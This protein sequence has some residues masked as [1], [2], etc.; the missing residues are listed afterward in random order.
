MNYS[1]YKLQFNTGVHF[2]TGVL[3]ESE[4]TFRAD[5][6]FSAL[7]IEALKQ[8]SEKEL[9][10]AVC[11]G[12]LLFSD[13]FPYKGSC[14]MLPKPM[15]YVEPADRGKSEQKKAYKNMKFIPV[16]AL[17]EFLCG[18]MD[19]ENNAMRDYGHYVQHTMACVR[20][21]DETLPF[22]VGTYYYNSGCG[23]YIIVGYQSEAEMLLSEELLD[24]LSYSGI[25][26]KKSSGLG[27]FELKIASGTDKLL[28][29]LYRD[30]GRSM[31]LSTALPKNEEL[32]RALDGATY[33]LERRSGFVASDRYADEWRKKRD[34]YV[35]ASG[36]CFVNRFDG[37]IIDV[38]DGGRHSVYRYAKPVFIGI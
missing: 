8:G 16:E 5:Q 29:M 34:L 24:S 30:T 14:Y 6:L 36:S 4:Y 19:V 33:L 21:G 13:L 28:D 2:G 20:T 18:R 15:L 31:L 11:S 32:E 9:Y 38:S 10:E 25:G 37:D 1:I 7:Y 3:S 22:R 23:L 17:D 27:K 35:F 26:G 12:N